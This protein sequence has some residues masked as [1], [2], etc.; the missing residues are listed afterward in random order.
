MNKD[1]LTIML[2][3]PGSKGPKALNL[4]ISHLKIAAF[5]FIFFTVVSLISFGSTYTFYRA[6]ESKTRSV[7]HLANTID[8]LSHDLLLNKST[9]AGLR[10]KMMNIENKLLEMQEMLDKKGIKKDL[11]VGG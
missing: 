4:K 5:S 2:I 6:S 11:A 1:H 10:N 9:E 3:T 7:K 8:T